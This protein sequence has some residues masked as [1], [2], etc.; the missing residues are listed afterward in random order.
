MSHTQYI[1]RE[2]DQLNRLIDKKIIRGRSYRREAMRH[3]VLLRKLS[4]ARFVSRGNS[5]PV[6]SW[7]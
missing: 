2:I 6:F 7:F 1:T 3:K 5:L 4:G